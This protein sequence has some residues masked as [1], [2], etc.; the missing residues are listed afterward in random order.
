MN[1]SRL[2]ARLVTLPTTG[3]INHEIEML[4]EARSA[5]MDEIGLIGRGRRG[6]TAPGA[7]WE[8]NDD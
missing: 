2:P 8:K 4:I 1:L 7:D 3:W 5:V 6:A